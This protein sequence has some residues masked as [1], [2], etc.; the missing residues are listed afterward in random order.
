[1]ADSRIEQIRQR[2]L[3]LRSRLQQA[4]KVVEAGR[5]LLDADKKLTPFGEGAWYQVVSALRAALDAYEK[6]GDSTT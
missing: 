1:V 4:E 3:W 5:E 2:E 6:G